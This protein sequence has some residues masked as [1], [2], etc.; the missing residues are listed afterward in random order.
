M[1][2]IQ[3]SAAILFQGGHISKFVYVDDEFG[4]DVFNGI[5]DNMVDERRVAEFM[6]VVRSVRE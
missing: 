1:G 4:R 3:D 2:N 5:F 6:E